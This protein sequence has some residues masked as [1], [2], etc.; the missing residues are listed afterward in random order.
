MIQTQEFCTIKRPRILVR[1]AKIAA[2]HFHRETALR[3]IM[4]CSIVPPKGKALQFLTDQEAH[5]NTL[6]LEG[7]ASYS[8]RRHINV[9]A[10]LLV[11]KSLL[12]VV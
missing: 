4:K 8:M 2:Q 5:L 10:A 6:R 3:R 1:A 12:R 9:L 7:E 11:E